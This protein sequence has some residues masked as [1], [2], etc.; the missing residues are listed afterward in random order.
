LK[1]YGHYIIWLDYLDSRLSRAQGRRVQVSRAVPAPTLQELV[2]AAKALGLEAQAQEASHP[3]RHRIKS[4]FIMVRKP[5]MGKSKL[6]NALA[7]EL[8]RIRGERAKA[9]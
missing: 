7:R 9:A 1:E 8:S 6:L 2:Q 4:G 3:R 5:G